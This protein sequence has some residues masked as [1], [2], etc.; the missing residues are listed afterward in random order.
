MQILGI[1]S[2]R[3]QSPSL[4][5]R[6]EADMGFFKADFGDIQTRCTV[7]KNRGNVVVWKER[8]KGSGVAFIA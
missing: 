8:K 5:R 2:K 3:R 4:E 7:L 6:E 1:P